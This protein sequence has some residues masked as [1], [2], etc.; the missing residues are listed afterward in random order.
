MSEAHNLVGKLVTIITDAASRTA[1]P[2]ISLKLRAGATILDTLAEEFIPALEAN[3]PKVAGILAAF[4]KLE[5]D[6]DLV[7][8]DIQAL[9]AAATATTAPASTEST[10]A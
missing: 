10:T 8:N 7:T 1:D 4:E 5:T 2:A 3:N 9:V 6:L